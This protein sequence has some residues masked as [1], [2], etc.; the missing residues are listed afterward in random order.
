MDFQ[1]TY[2]QQLQMQ[3]DRHDPYLNYEVDPRGSSPEPSWSAGFEVSEREVETWRTPKW[4]PPVVDV[5]PV[6]KLTTDEE[7]L[8]FKFDRMHQHRYPELHS[9]KHGATMT[10]YDLDNPSRSRKIGSYELD[11]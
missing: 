9:C 10:S 5:D 1:P 2:L 8:G 7:R 3:T 11:Y 6:L 4:E